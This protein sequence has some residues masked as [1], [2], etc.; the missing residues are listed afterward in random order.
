MQN[1]RGCAKKSVM[2]FATPPQVH[3]LPRL[4]KGPQ[5][6]IASELWDYCNIGN[7]FSFLNDH[8]CRYSPWKYWSGPLRP[9]VSASKQTNHT[10]DQREPITCEGSPVETTTQKYRLP[11][12]RNRITG[13]GIHQSSRLAVGPGPCSKINKQN[14]TKQNTPF[15][16]MAHQEVIALS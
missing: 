13:E 2:T 3:L 5:T 1:S 7:L 16:F 12:H 11:P 9:R 8:L 14:I 4:K 6:G 10:W 15:R